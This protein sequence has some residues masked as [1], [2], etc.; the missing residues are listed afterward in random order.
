MPILFVANLLFCADFTLTAI[1]MAEWKKD[2]REKPQE[3]DNGGEVEQI[4]HD[5]DEDAS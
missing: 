5:H 2:P 3:S 1:S 4:W